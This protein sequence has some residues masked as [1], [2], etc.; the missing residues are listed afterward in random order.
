MM[1]KSKKKVVV[2]NN[3]NKSSTDWSVGT[4]ALPGREIFGPLVLIL[5]TPP[6]SMIFCHVCTVWNGDFAKFGRFVWS[7]TNQNVSLWHQLVNLWPNPWNPHVWTMIGSFLALELFLMKAVPGKEFKATM[8]PNGN[9]P[10]YKANGT[11]CYVI[12][13]LLFVSLDY[14]GWFDLASVYDHFGQILS[15]MN[16][17]ALLFCAFLTIKGYVAPS[18]SD[19]GTTGNLLNDF[20]WGMELYPQL[21][22]FWDVKQLT[23]CRA[24]MMFWPLAVLS[25]CYKNMDLHNGQLQNGLAV[26]VALQLVYCTKFFHVS[27]V[28]CFFCCFVCCFFVSANMGYYSLE[29]I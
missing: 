21:F 19:S 24:G 6:F 18:S 7:Q 8:T 26:S 16:V 17:L 10:T 3:N 20:Y 15:S 13:M 28:C 2:V 25:F 29:Y 12:T 27:F 5:V 1:S 23:N 4:G 14:I 22:W 11:A 9:I